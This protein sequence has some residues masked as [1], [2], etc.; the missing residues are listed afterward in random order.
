MTPI[1]RA[2][3][4]RKRW[5]ISAQAFQ[6][7]F[8]WSPRAQLPETLQQ[9]HDWYVRTGQLSSAVLGYFPA[10]RRALVRS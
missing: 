9:T 7:T 4:G 10:F 5:V 1:V 6:E 3:F 2:K 8:G